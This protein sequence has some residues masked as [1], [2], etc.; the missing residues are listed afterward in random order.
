MPFKH[1]GP[2]NAITD[3]LYDICIPLHNDVAFQHGLQF[4]AKVKKIIKTFLICFSLR[5][6]FIFG[7]KI[8]LILLSHVVRDDNDIFA[9]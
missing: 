2:Y 7:Q 4:D 9:Q 6:T 8:F 3:D 5:L 1:N